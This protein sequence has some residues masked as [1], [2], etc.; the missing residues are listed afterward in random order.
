MMSFD[1]NFDKRTRVGLPS[2]WDQQNNF[3][4]WELYETLL[5]EEKSKINS[6]HEKTG[7]IKGATI[8][9]YLHKDFQLAWMM[10]NLFIKKPT[11]N[12]ITYFRISHVKFKNSPSTSTNIW[13]KT[14]EWISW[15][16]VAIEAEPSTTPQSQIIWNEM[17][18]LEVVYFQI[19]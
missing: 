14:R 7:V 4:S 6:T 18:T 17:F 9:N 5:V 2:C 10:E 12:R 1:I 19:M 13:R 8:V 16:I 15:Q 3:L 11:Y